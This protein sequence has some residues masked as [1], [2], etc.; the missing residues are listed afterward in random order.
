MTSHLAVIDMQQVFGE[1]SSPWAT[2]GFDAIVPTVKA[3]VAAFG[4]DVTFTRFVAP[5]QPRGGWVDYYAQWPF[6]LRPPDAPLWDL[7][8]GFAG[9]TVDATTFGKWDALAERVGSA[10]LVLCGVST[11][12]CVLSTALAAADAG[13]TVKV[14]A[15][16]CAGLSDV[17]H[18]RALDTMSLY[19]PL[20]EIV[21]TQTVSAQTVSASVTVK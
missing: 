15:D 13:V 7:A 10:G 8:A 16:A 14:V 2:P 3:L 4:D 21:S 9:P 20:I 19:A 12:C 1:P 18:Q 6:A 5:A 11:D 17:D